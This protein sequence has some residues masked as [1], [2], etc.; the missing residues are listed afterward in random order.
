[1]KASELIHGGLYIIHD[2]SDVV[3]R[4]DITSNS[5]KSEWYEYPLA[6]FHDEVCATEGD[7]YIFVKP[8]PLS[9]EMLNANGIGEEGSLSC[10]FYDG[11]NFF[12]D[13]EKYGLCVQVGS[14]WFVHQLQHALLLCKLNTLA[15]KFKL[16]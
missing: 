10:T 5:F 2:A 3:V 6:L 7:R 8:I 1:M 15:D 14:V 12:L 16:E 13:N 11:Y 4:Y 9:E